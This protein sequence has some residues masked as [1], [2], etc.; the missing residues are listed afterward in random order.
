MSYPVTYVDGA[1][2]SWGSTN[3]YS[4]LLSKIV[5]ASAKLALQGSAHDTT[6]LGTATQT[7]IVGLAQ[8][9]ASIQAQG[10]AT[11]RV[12]NAGT[13]TIAGGGA[14]TYGLHVQ[15]WE[16]NIVAEERDI[17]EMT[18]A[19][20]WMSWRPDGPV[21]IT[22][23]LTMRADSATAGPL[24]NLIGDTLAT[25]TLKYGADVA[26][27][28]V[29]SAANGALLRN[30]NMTL[31]KGSLTMYEAD[32]E[33]ATGV[34]TPTGTNSIFPLTGTGNVASGFGL[35]LWAQGGAAVGAMVVTVAS[36]HT[37][38]LADSFWK[39]IRLQCAVGSPVE[40]NIEARATGAVTAA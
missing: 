12:G 28:Q 19:P 33:T 11:P 30:V 39:S 7:Q 18:A 40:L 36:G 17:T 35:P 38:S 6:A 23:K 25:V 15:S 20:T 37:Y 8:C 24:P 34:W 2:T 16:L 4:N 5:P 3:F 27:D 1:L 10:F 31:Q 29:A 13:V 32:F 14:W 22:G 26:A 9:T 21:K